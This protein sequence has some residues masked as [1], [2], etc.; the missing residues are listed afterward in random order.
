VAVVRIGLAGIR[1]QGPHGANP[2]E[3][4]RPQ[5]FVVDVDTVVETSADELEGT[6]D[7]RTLAITVRQTVEETSYVLL[8]SL[9]QA[10][11]EAVGAYPNV[12]E[13][14]AIVHKP[15]AAA[16]LGV[17]DVAAEATVGA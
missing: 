5:T 17:D 10:I 4:D 12:L 1:A 13:A 3:R 2:G 14:T 7:Y 6:L 8:E 11:A 9:A 16:S 15:S